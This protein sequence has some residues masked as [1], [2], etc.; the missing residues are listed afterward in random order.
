MLGINVKE[1]AKYLK[2]IEKS[3]PLTISC[4]Q[5]ASVLNIKQDSNK[6]C[7]EMAFHLVNM[8]SEVMEIPELDYASRIVMSS[9]RLSKII[10]DMRQ[11]DDTL[12]IRCAQQQALFMI[13]GQ[14]GQ[15]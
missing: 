13:Q 6:G 12:R 7:V 14:S 9:N 8:E 5:N 2:F 1:L 4:G 3:D 11:L 10:R 15:I